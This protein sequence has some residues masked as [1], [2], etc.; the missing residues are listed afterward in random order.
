[1]AHREFL[2]L[3]WTLPNQLKVILIPF[4]INKT[5]IM[6]SFDGSKNVT[7]LKA[8]RIALVDFD[9]PKDAQKEYA[10]NSLYPSGDRCLSWIPVSDA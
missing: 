1:M 5:L 7:F 6:N 4:K 9:S 3:D 8:S 10:F 2:Q